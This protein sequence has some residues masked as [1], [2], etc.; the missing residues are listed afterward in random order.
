MTQILLMALIGVAI[1]YVSHI[2]SSINEDYK[3][4]EAKDDR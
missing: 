1:I 4:A 3:K 2:C